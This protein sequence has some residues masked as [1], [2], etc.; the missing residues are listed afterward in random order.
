MMSESWEE[1]E[2]S[3]TRLKV[4]GHLP[5]PEQVFP[6]PARA[7]HLSENASPEEKKAALAV[8]GARWN[9]G[10]ERWDLVPFDALGEV[11]RV[12]TVG[13]KKYADRN[14]EKGMAWHICIGATFRHFW[15]WLLSENLDPETNCHHLAHAIWN[16]MALLAY[17]MRGMTEFDD[18]K[19][20]G[21]S[22]QVNQQ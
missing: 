16:L 2:D 20:N 21:P 6:E 7:V 19:I 22:K 11:V 1:W 9:E 18:R 15:K 10:K 13:A 17:Q 5:S 3:L 12:Y 8:G 4:D 14:W